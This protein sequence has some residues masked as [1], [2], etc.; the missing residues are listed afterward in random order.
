[1]KDNEKKFNFKNVILTMICIFFVCAGGIFF[2]DIGDYEEVSQG[3]F[4]DPEAGNVIIVTE[5]KTKVSDYFYRTKGF[6]ITDTETGE[7]IRFSLGNETECSSSSR[8]LGN[9]RHQS[10][11][12]ISYGTIMNKI[13]EKYPDWAQ[14]I[15]N[16]TAGEI[17]FDAIIQVNKT[18]L[19]SGTIA[20][21][22]STLDGTLYDKDNW[23]QLIIDFPELAFL[24][25]D[26][27]MHYEKLLTILDGEWILGPDGKWTFKPR[28]PSP[29]PITPSPTPSYDPDEGRNPEYV[30]WI[31]KEFPDIATYNYDP[32]GKFVIG[33]K[34]NNG[35]QTG[36]IPSSE[37]I[38]NGYEANEWY[39]TAD[40]NR[41]ISADHSWTFTGDVSITVHTGQY[42]QVPNDDE[43]PS[44]G[45]HQEE[46]T[47]TTS[48]KGTGNVDRSVRYWY[49]G[50]GGISGRGGVWIYDLLT[51]ITTNTVFPGGRH[52]YQNYDPFSL[53]CTHDG[54]DLTSV[55][56]CDYIPDD[57]YHVDWN[58][59]VKYGAA[60]TY[61]IS[62][63]TASCKIG[64]E[65]AA[66]DEAIASAAES[67]IEPNE[68]IW[69]R[70]DELTIE[71]HTY[72]SS[73]Y[74]Q[75]KDFHE[76]FGEENTAYDIPEDAYGKITEEQTAAIPPETANGDYETLITCIYQRKALENGILTE[77][78]DLHAIKNG[79]DPFGHHYEA[80]N[81]KVRVHTPTVS[82]VEVINP[83]TGEKYELKD[84]Q[85]QLVT[86]A[87]NERADYQFLLD[88]TYTIRFTPETHFEH[89]GYDDPEL[90]SSLYEKYCS[91]REVCF[92]FVVQVN[93]RI[94]TP[95]KE[96]VS[97]DQDG[98]LECGRKKLPGYTD[99]IRLPDGAQE[100]EFYIP[101]WAVEDSD[102]VVQFRVAPI[103]VVD[104]KK[105]D[106]I[107]DYTAWDYDWEQLK[108]QSI[109]IPGHGSSDLYEYVSTYSFTCQ[110]SGI[111]Y[112]FQAVGINDKDR[113]EGYKVQANGYEVPNGFGIANYF[114]FCPTYQEKRSGIY[115]RFGNPS[116]RY[117]FDGTLT[118]DWNVANTLPFSTGKSLSSR[119]GELR[120]GNTFA[121]TVKTIANLGDEDA[122]MD[123]STTGDCIIIKPTF[124]YVSNDGTVNRDVDVYYHTDTVDGKDEHLFVAFG[125]SRD[126]ETKHEVSISDLR[127]NG[128]YYY[129]SGRYEPDQ[130]QIVNKDMMNVLSDRYSLANENL[131]K[132]HHDDA[133]FSKDCANVY[134]KLLAEDEGR[135]GFPD[136]AYSTTSIFL[137]RKTNSYCLS[138]IVLNSRL[139]LLTGNVEQLKMNENNEG[140]SLQYLDD[141]LSNGT[142]YKVTP[143][144]CEAY[145][146]KY[147]I[148]HRRSMQTWF[149]TYWIPNQLFVTDDVFEADTDGDGVPE[150]YDTLW[151][152]ANAKGHIA[153]ND[154]I[155]KNTGYLV[156]NF[157]IYTKNDGQDH[158]S[159][160]GSN[161]DMWKI[162]GQPDTVHVGDPNIPG[163]TVEIEVDSGDVA[164]IDL[165]RS[166]MDGWTTGF[167]R[168]N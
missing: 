168:I 144:T 113:F 30:T 105:V 54:I 85:T 155:F 145:D 87:V 20:P 110:V 118:D 95:T 138:E 69:V 135:T 24:E 58:R 48:R 27:A 10:Q 9:G 19:L 150:K 159:Y 50:T 3:I 98:E 100:V 68:N 158:L 70:N 163:D 37:D 154:P 124:R 7:S 36:G 75:F 151:D 57:D 93:G 94:Y 126:L 6:T 134:Q 117:S 39:G 74:Y 63:A 157:Q 120:R 52:V 123:N 80:D 165:E 149:G 41:R 78:G 160:I 143:Q 1:M 166:I 15:S 111:I 33:A 106:H 26:I 47:Y 114:A 112:D 162:E 96:S 88:G 35:S 16:N 61:V 129:R 73:A 109:T 64:G 102:H 45:Y 99:W 139:R 59:A 72:M 32:T 79:Y 142:S 127:F 147:W 122:L 12:D 76:N 141:R 161:A 137:D 116:V 90:V 31:G 4:N 2:A 81:E 18:G 49:L 115:N 28:I 153:E 53:I 152:Y 43:D 167:N 23:E 131:R 60:E 56:E 46:Y 8:D 136:E 101:S 104:H 21:D 44:K 103:N 92:P 132:Y 83:D 86:S 97:E 133:E 125:E 91:F 13:S 34:Y 77:T 119:D 65:K 62:G 55:E 29:T 51:S 108:N 107:E 5:D 40:I 38:T 42:Y 14:R 89:I 82:P 148:R 156:V 164:V 17:Q 22:G 71:G 140:D 121:F 25:T 146:Q 11:W 128:S 130:R 67:H 84:M 66:A